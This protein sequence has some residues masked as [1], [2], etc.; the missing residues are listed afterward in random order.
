M[1]TINNIFHIAIIY[2]CNILIL[3][4]LILNILILNI[5]LLT[6]RSGAPWLYVVPWGIERLLLHVRRSYGNPTVYVTESGYVDTSGTL[7]DKERVDYYRNYLKYLH[8]GKYIFLY[9]F[10]LNITKFNASHPFN[11][12][13]LVS[14]RA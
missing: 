5:L 3:N 6:R 8:S 4:I 14:Q 7:D 11:V 12:H 1:I 10:V 13:F 9:Q 2:V